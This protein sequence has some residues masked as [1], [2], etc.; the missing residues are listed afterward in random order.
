MSLVWPRGVIDEAK[1]T[2][3]HMAAIFSKHRRPKKENN[4]TVK[5]KQGVSD[6]WGCDLE[7]NKVLGLDLGQAFV[8]GASA[9]L[10]NSDIGKGTNAVVNGHRVLQ[11]GCQAES[12]VSATLKLR[13]WMEQRKD[14]AIYNSASISSIETNLPRLR[15]TRASIKEYVGR[16]KDVEAHIDSLYNSNM[17]LKKHRRNARKARDEEY[18]Q[19]ANRLFKLVGGS[20]GAKRKDSIKVAIGEGLGKLST[21]TRLSSLHKSFQSYFVQKD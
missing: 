4:N 2:Q 3:I 5:T 16:L 11:P 21:K 18:L 8:I 19:I 10:S 7:R 12:G 9:L 1:N 13:R 20:I 17:V 14:K 15:G 6:L